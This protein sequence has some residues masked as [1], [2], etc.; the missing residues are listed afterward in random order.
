MLEMNNLPKNWLCNEHEKILS[1]VQRKVSQN[2]VQL[3]R[4]HV[5][6]D[7]AVVRRKATKH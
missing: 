6:F 2:K 7:V 1:G 3:E 5:L 4:P